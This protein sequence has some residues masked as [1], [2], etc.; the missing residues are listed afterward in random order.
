MRKNIIFK[1]LCVI[2]AVSLV[3]LTAAGCGKK[4]TGNE[5]LD[6]YSGKKEFKQTEYSNIIE[7]FK[8]Q[9]TVYVNLAPDG[10]TSNITV[11]D[12]IH[13]DMPQVRVADISNLKNIRNVRTLTA[14]VTDDE[15]IYW[16][17]DTTDLYYS[18]ET[19]KETP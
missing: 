9:E 10:T 16:D 6:V 2:L 3:L 19:V 1:S 15:N 11:T 14:P 13:T 12:W 4:T 5:M 18:G 7:K 17:M 8:K